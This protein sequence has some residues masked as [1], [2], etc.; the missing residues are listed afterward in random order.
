MKKLLLLVL[1][2]LSACGTRNFKN[3]FDNSPEQLNAW[4]SRANI[5]QLCDG[6]FTYQDDSYVVNRILIEFNRRN[7]S[8]LNCRQYKGPK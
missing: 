2:L 5:Q 3:D 8:Y 1:F 7:V 6:L 4:S